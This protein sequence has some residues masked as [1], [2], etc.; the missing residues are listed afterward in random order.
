MGVQSVAGS[1][2]EGRGGATVVLLFVV[3]VDW[4]ELEMDSAVVKLS[5]HLVVEPGLDPSSM[6]GFLGSWGSRGQMLRY[7]DP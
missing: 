6:G 3:V 5:E 4:S 1:G 7:L 2:G